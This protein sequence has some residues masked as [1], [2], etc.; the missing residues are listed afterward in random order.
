MTYVPIRKETFGL[1][2]TGKK[3]CD[4]GGIDLG[5]CCHESVNTEDH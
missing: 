2:N 1:K 3:Q 5:R 4:C